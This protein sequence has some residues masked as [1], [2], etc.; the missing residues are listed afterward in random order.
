MHLHAPMQ[1]DLTDWWKICEN[2]RRI[3]NILTVG[4]NFA[5]EFLDLVVINFDSFYGHCG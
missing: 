1:P 5:T 2:C 3:K 4:Q